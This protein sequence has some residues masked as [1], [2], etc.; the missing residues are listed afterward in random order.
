MPGDVH[1]LGTPLLTNLTFQYHLLELLWPEVEVNYTYWPNGAKRGKN[2]VFITPGVVL[3]RI[4]LY[5]RLTLTVGTGYQFQENSCPIESL[6]T[7]V[8]YPWV[9]SKLVLRIPHG[10]DAIAAE[11]RVMSGNTAV[12]RSKS[13]APN[14]SYEATSR[15]AYTAVLEPGERKRDC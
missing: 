15:S 3:G 1:T 8:G 4:R 6:S 11:V 7:V 12:R 13:N 5:G 14:W 10:F 2:Q 9:R